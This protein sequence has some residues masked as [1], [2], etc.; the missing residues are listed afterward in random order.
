MRSTITRTAKRLAKAGVTF[1]VVGGPDTEPADVD[2]SLSVLHELHDGRWGD[3][4]GF[5]ASW[6]SFAV[7]ARSG[8]AVGEVRFHELVSAD[9]EIV[10]IETDF[11]VGGRMSFYQAGRLTE[12]E[13]RGSGRCSATT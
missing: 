2:R 13:L 1:R 5:L 4:S 6:D 9:G 7:A 3:E 12:H 8:A 11:V 10:A